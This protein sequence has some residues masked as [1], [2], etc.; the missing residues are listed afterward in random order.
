MKQVKGW[1]VRKVIGE[2]CINKNKGKTVQ[3]EVERNREKGMGIKK[4]VIIIS[5]LPTRTS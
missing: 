5:G 2:G 3:E 4:W 1:D